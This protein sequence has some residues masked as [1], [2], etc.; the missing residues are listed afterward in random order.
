MSKNSEIENNL[1][2]SELDTEVIESVKKLETDSVEMTEAHCE[3]KVELSMCP[4]LPTDQSSSANSN[5]PD[6]LE[7]IKEPE[8][9][10]RTTE[11][12]RSRENLLDI[13]RNQP[14]QQRNPVKSES[15]PIP[16]GCQRNLADP[17]SDSESTVSL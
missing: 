1:I 6:F 16:G 13:D 9:L 15:I 17:L 4:S 8:E 14:K 10:D 7:S 2:A 5:I 3:G 11:K 12:S